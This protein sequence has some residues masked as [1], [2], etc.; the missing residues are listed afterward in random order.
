[1]K[2]IHDEINLTLNLIQ[3]D[4]YEGSLN[5]L[6]HHLV[7]LLE[8]KRNE[9]QKRLDGCSQAE[10]KPLTTKELLAG[11]WWCGDVSE[12]CRLAF[13]ANGSHTVEED[14]EK[15]SRIRCA[16]RLVNDEGILRAHIPIDVSTLKQ[17]YRIGSDFYWSER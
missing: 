7:C 14:W 13:V 10:T 9:I 15:T 4:I 3:Q 8:I 16:Y 12:E 11:G 2:E 17:I 1:M 5:E 6:Q